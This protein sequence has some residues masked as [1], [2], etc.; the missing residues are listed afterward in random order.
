MRYLINKNIM[1]RTSDGALWLD[2]E[3]EFAITLTITTCR[4]LTFLLE[5]QGQVVL[6]DEILTQVW[7]A[8]GLKSSNNSLNK[9][10]SDLRSVFRN[11][12]INE[13]VIVTVPRVGFMLTAD[14]D[15]I[16]EHPVD[17][18][19]HTVPVT[20]EAIVNSAG[21]GSNTLFDKI[22]DGVVS[23]T[24]FFY[25]AIFVALFVIAASFFSA[26]TSSQSASRNQP[27]TQR[28]YALGD[29]DGCQVS[30][31]TSSTPQS[32]ELKLSI[33]KRILEKEKLTCP[34]DGV[35]FLQSSEP[36]LYGTAG[37]VF[38]SICRNNHSNESRYSS[39]YNIY[40]VSHAL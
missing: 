9:Y 2:N 38:L 32:T 33:V 3:E 39:C 15:V 34:V 18:V 14:I 11:R 16:P 27:Q 30:S 1:F 13:D 24:L 8:H 23:N 21:T 36:V 22:K 19:I 7:D 17:S 4:L 25:S 29:I 31:F 5:R 20:Q 6:R 28:T 37:R 40:E 12:G 10:I 35:L 26:I